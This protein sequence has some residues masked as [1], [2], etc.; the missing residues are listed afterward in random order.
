MLLLAA[1]L[2]LAVP[3]LRLTEMTIAPDCLI[4]IAEPDSA[5]AITARQGMLSKDTKP[6]FKRAHSIYVDRG[7]ST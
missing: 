6:E 1:T 2:L 4:V 7:L 5:S 3:G